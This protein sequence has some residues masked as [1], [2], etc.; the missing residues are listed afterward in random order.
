MLDGVLLETKVVHHLEFGSEVTFG[1]VGGLFV[2]KVQLASLCR[3]VVPK[4]T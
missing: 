3:M 1:G 4:D 2:Q